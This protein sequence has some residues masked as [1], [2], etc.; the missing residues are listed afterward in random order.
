MWLGRYKRD[1]KADGRILIRVT[2]RRK[3]AYKKAAGARGLTEWMIKHC[4]A[5]AAYE[6]FQSETSRR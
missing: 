4:D 3:A 2:P 6:D 1:Q 5:A